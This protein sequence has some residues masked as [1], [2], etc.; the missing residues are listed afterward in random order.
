MHLSCTIILPLSL[1]F[2]YNPLLFVSSSFLGGGS[3]SSA[4]S[5][6]A[7]IYF[8]FATERLSILVVVQQ[9]KDEYCLTFRNSRIKNVVVR[10]VRRVRITAVVNYWVSVEKLLLQ[11]QE[12]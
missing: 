7:A 5:D 8:I 1:F 12:S 2:Q 4:C 6:Q 11:E 9:I 10:V 3:V